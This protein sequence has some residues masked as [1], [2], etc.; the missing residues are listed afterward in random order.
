M[1][2]PQL[3]FRALLNNQRPKNEIKDIGNYGLLDF[4]DIKRL[5]MYLKG[6]IFSR[7]CCLYLG[8]IKNKYSTISYKGKKVSVLRLI[9][10]NYVDDITTS[11]TLEYTCQNAGT[12]CNINHYGIKNKNKKRVQKIDIEDIEPFHE[13]AEEEDVFSFD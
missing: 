9:Y 12:C 10:H 7:S 5:D 2:S 6:N 4:N 8:E 11:D 3:N 1:S 13:S